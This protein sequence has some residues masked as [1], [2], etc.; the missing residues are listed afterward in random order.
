MLSKD[1]YFKV[2]GFEFPFQCDCNQTPALET[3][4][5]FLRARFQIFE[6][7]SV[8]QHCFENLEM[9]NC[10]QTFISKCILIFSVLK[11]V[12]QNATLF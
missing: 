10:F 8:S 4:E 7:S 6:F 5:P 3:F 2:F 12:S 9:Q 1:P 11:L